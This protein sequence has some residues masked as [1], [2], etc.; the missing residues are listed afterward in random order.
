MKI[1]TYQIADFN[2]TDEKGFSWINSITLVNKTTEQ[3]ADELRKLYPRT[4]V[5]LCRVRDMT[6]REIELF[7]RENCAEEYYKKYGTAGEF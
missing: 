4:S 6:W 5:S 7:E 2:V 3:A 1:R